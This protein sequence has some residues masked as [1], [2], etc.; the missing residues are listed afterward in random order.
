MDC[1]RK[2]AHNNRNKVVPVVT[3]GSTMDMTAITELSYAVVMAWY[4]G[5]EGRYALGDLL[6]GDVNFSGRLP[7]TFP[8][9]VEALPAFDDY[10]MQGRTYKYMNDNIMF[11]FG[12]GLTYCDVAYS[13]AKIL[14]PKNKGKKKVQ[15]QVNMTNNGDKAAV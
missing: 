5:Q 12:Y 13:E 1:I 2:V 10:T 14:N 11:P 6:F 8:L 15:V 9:S 3:R 4:P 7:V